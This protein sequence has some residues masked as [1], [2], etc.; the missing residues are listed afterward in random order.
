MVARFGNLG[1]CSLFVL[2]LGAVAGCGESTPG[3][4]PPPAPGGVEARLA[5]SG[6][7]PDPDGYTVRVDDGPARPVGL[8]GTVRIEVAAGR[9]VVT[10]EGVA[11]NCEVT[12]GNARVVTVAAGGTARVSFRGTRRLRPA[13]SSMT[14]GR[15]DGAT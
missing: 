14:R 5:T 3:P 13:V 12:D 8:N 4:P 7:D 11:A 9:H 6:E 15:G 2:I 1:L 10:L